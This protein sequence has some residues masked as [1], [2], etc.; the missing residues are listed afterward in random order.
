MGELFEQVFFQVIDDLDAGEAK[1][2]HRYLELVPAAE[3]DEL[4]DLLAAVLAARG[5]AGALTSAESESYARALAVIRQASAGK[6]PS[7]ALPDLIV[8]IRHSR[9]I[10]RGTVIDGLAEHFDVGAA[11]RRA[12]RRL[13]HQLESGQLLGS[14]LSRRLLAA[15]GEILDIDER[16]LEAA[17]KPSG[18]SEPS[19][20]TLSLARDSGQARSRTRRRTTVESAAAAA[21]EELARRLFTGGRD[22]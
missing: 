7:G 5:P 16:D 9:G 22:A 6:G 10:E 17:S 12:L 18:S 15:L 19:A 3:R 20:P 4:A 11:G 8:R 14:R 13:Y 21:E 1:S 2:L